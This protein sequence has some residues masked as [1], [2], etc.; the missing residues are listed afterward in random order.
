MLLAIIIVAVALV[1][2]LGVIR[3]RN[4]WTRGGPD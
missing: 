2:T 1:I 3:W 4:R